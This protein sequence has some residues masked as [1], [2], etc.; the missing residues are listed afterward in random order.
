MMRRCEPQRRLLIFLYIRY[1]KNFQ[2]TFSYYLL[3]GYVDGGI[4][5]N[6]P[7][8][9]AASKV[10]S[11][12]PTVNTRN[13]TVLSLGAGTFPRHTDIFS[14]NSD[15]HIKYRQ[16]RSDGSPEILRADWGIK[17]W[18]SI[19]NICDNITHVDTLSNG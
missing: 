7:S 10:L 17:Q 8:I 19:H 15:A 18:V 5:A 13:L 16:N 11:H 14:F 9:I 2:N 3:Q 6:N 1:R 12:Y 4:V